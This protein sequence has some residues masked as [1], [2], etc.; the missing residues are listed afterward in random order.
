[1]MRNLGDAL[2]RAAAAP[3]VRAVVLSG[4]GA[5][6]CTGM[7]LSASAQRDMRAE[8]QQSPTTMMLQML[9]VRRSQASTDPAHRCVCVR[10]SLFQQR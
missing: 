10:D 1:M 3:A 7:D 5:H 6:F 4:R 9:E 8:P 2:G